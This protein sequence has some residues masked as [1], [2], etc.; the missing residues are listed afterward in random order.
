MEGGVVLTYFVE[1]YPLLDSVVFNRKIFE[2]QANG[3]MISR[4]L[5]LG[6]RIKEKKLRKQIQ[7]T[8]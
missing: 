5:S 1:G 2:L 3:D 4:T 7:L 6:L 8:K